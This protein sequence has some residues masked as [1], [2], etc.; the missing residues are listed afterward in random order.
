MKNIYISILALFIGMC[1]VTAQVGLGTSSPNENAVLEVS[2][3]TQGMAFPRVAAMTDIPN[4]ATGLMVFDM[5]GDC[6]AVNVG[7]PAAPDWKCTGIST[8]ERIGIEADE[9]NIIPSIVTVEELNG[10]EGVSAAVLANQ[11]DYQTYIDANPDLFSS[12][13]TV[14]EVNAMITAVNNEKSSTT[15]GTLAQVGLEGDDPDTTN[16]VVTAAQLAAVTGVTGVDADNETAY[17]DYIDDNP[18]LFSSPATVEEVNEMIAAVNNEADAEAGENGAVSTL[19]KLGTEAD[20][21]NETTP[22]TV[23][24]AELAAVSGVTGVD[25]DNEAAYQAYI[26]ENPDLFSSPATV[27][28]VN[29]MIAAVNNE[30]DAEAGENGA[31]S[32]LVKLGTE[33]DPPNEST[34]TTVTA[35][36]LAAVSGVTGVE[37]DNEAAYQAYINENPDLFSSPAT[38][39]E[40]NAMIAAVN[41]EADAEAGENGAVSTLEKLGTEADPPNEST[42][43]T[44]TAAELAAVSGVTGVDGDN[45]AAYQAY[46]NENPD[47]F[48]SPATVEEVNAMIAAVNNEADAEA[49]ENGAVSTLVKL[50]TEADPPNE[51][52]PTTVTAAELAAVSGVTGVDGDNEAAYQAYINENPDLFSSP[53]TVEEV[54]AMI[55][56]V[57]NEADAEAGENGAVSTLVKLGTEADPPNESTPTTV[58]AAELAAVSGVTGVEGDNE[59]AYQAYINENPDLFS[60]P[61]TVEEVNAMIAAVNNEADAEAGENGAVSTLEKL[62]TE[63]DPPNESTPTTVTAAELAAVSGVTGVD[64]DNEAAYQA[65][66]NEN[67]DLFSSPATVAEVNAMIAAVNNEADAE[68]GENGAVS[69]LEKLGTEA[70]PP[71]ESTPTTVTAAELAAVS[72]VTGVDGDNEAAYQAYIDANPDLFSS[73]ATVAEVNAMIA[74]VNNEADAEAGENGAVSTLEKL[75]TE[76]DPPNESTPTTVTAAELAAVSG[77][78]GVDGDNEAAYQAYINNNPDLFSS[79]ATVA[80]VNAM[81]AAVNANEETGGED[82]ILVQIGTEADAGTGTPSTVT[83]AQLAALTGITGVD[84]DNEADYQQYIADNPDAFSQPATLAEVQAMI[85][86]VNAANATLPEGMEI[87]N[88]DQNKYVV[89]IFDTDYEPAPDPLPAATLDPIVG[90][91]TPDTLW[92][93]LVS[94]VPMAVAMN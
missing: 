81:I 52:T 80:E 47:L 85:D 25:G 43:T 65:Y 35:A 5:V 92:T 49:G 77:V 15:G 87:T 3:T 64:G 37:G 11:A 14:V 31:V 78:I 50:G 68:A 84:P 59:A 42:P 66:I 4:P 54:N 75:G 30:A 7:T 69:T 1:S 13:A 48:S 28:E 70:D 55:A 74:A 67:P 22:T 6:L 91:G 10:I 19:V 82:S 21:P 33:A 38:V 27:E 73:P 93:Y 17:Q 71:N 41:N 60:S 36:E 18:D 39:A 16:S 94:L 32:T 45:E 44:V 76:A 20:P 29:A 61:A 2:S 63:A 40:V 26:N 79:P 88:A 83:A 89:S 56:A 86:A 51:S 34:P 46:I 72:G 62:G 8:L 24:A 57:N 53:A 9:A 23:T 58:T 90:D 12:P